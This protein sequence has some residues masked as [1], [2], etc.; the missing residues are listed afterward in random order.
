M[1]I[2]V[3]P[4]KERGPVFTADSAMV[5]DCGRLL[6]RAKEPACAQ[7]VNPDLRPRWF[8]LA[9][10]QVAGERLAG[11]GLPRRSPFVNKLSEQDR[12]RLEAFVP[13]GNGSGPDG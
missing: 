7:V 1:I 3:V 10:G 6:A 8:E 2:T 5:S 9:R 13:Q 12:C 4:V 11:S